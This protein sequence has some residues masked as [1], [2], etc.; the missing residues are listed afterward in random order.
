MEIKYTI[1][2]CLPAANAHDEILPKAA[3]CKICKAPACLSYWESGIGD[4]RCSRC[5]VTYEGCHYSGRYRRKKKEAIRKWNEVN[6]G[7]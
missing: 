6:D 4:I 7:D 5:R 1:I 3:I 2:E